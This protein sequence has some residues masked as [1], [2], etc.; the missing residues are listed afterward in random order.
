MTNFSDDHEQVT[1]KNQSIRIE[2]PTVPGQMASVRE[3]TAP[4]PPLFTMPM[5]KQRGCLPVLGVSLL[6]LTFA[7]V[8]S[9]A[10]YIV[11]PPQPRDILVMGL[12]SRDGEGVVTRTDSIMLLGIDTNDLRLNLLSIPRDLYISAPD[13]GLQRINTINVLGEM[14]AVGNGPQLLRDSIALSFGIE[15]DAYVRLDFDAFKALVDAVGGV[16]IDV[17][18]EIVDTQFPTEDYGTEV[19]RFAAGRQHMNGETALKY[20]RTRHADDDYRRAERQQQ[21]LN[22]VAGK[23]LLPLYWPGVLNA[24]TQHVETDL[25]A[26]DVL[27]GLPPA[28]IS[29]V[30]FDQL[31]INRDYISGT[32]QGNAIPNYVALESWLEARF[33]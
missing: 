8:A 26:L 7:C 12:D 27:V 21:V 5:R 23:M 22:A 10:L 25:S 1:Q 3:M 13:Y 17:P 15:V 14:E 6:L 33:D 32:A 29:G 9:F 11:F 30:G 19:V 2:E 4:M 16:T 24:I 28:L 20:A 18:Y 31:V